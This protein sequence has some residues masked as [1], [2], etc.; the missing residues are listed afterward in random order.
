MAFWTMIRAVRAAVKVRRRLKGPLR[1]SWDE[2][3]ETWAAV[4]HHYSK[5][6]TLLPLSMQRNAPVAM[7]ARARQPLA[8]RFE[9]VSAGGVPAEWF[10][11][12]DWDPQRI[13]FYLHG[14]GYSI[15]SIDSH[16]DLIVRLCQASSATGL[17]IDYRLAPEF[18]FPAQLD[19]ALAAYRFLLDSGIQPDSLVIGGE[20]AGG[21]LTLSTLISLRDAGDPLPAAALCISPWVD[22]EAVTDS[23]AKNSRFDYIGKRALDVFARR[24]VKEHDLRHPLAAP[25]HAEL[26]G[27]PPLLIQVGGAETLL[28]DALRLAE[29]ARAAGVDTRLEVWDDMIHAWH[30]FAGFFE[31]SRRAIEQAGEFVRQHLRA[32]RAV[33]QS[34]S[35]ESTISS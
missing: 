31:P 19:D 33:V 9:R 34:P 13:L 24:F 30:L 20:S 29:R 17:A 35:S 26:A 23:I 10:R 27:L 25:L 12:P 16:R 4:M 11:H 8:V 22:L 2:D 32:E 5:H 18:P 28:D 1:P 21:G 7:A 15:G 3:Y 6:S 14:G